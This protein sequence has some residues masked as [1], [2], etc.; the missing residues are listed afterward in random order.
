MSVA[1]A[2]AQKDVVN[3]F[4]KHW[5]ALS[6]DDMAVLYGTD[7]EFFSFPTAVLGTKGKTSEEWAT[8][9][10]PMWAELSNFE[11]VLSITTLDR[12][13]C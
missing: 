7:F 12:R 2:T 5:K 13:V 3:A 10:E 6:V 11:V 4:I 1:R 8:F 9:I